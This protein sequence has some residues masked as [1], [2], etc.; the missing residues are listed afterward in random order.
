MI[1]FIVQFL[2]TFVLFF[3]IINLLCVGHDIKRIANA[4][5]DFVYDDE[6]DEEESEVK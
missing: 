6:D 1:E 3:I 4:L 5:E 2:I